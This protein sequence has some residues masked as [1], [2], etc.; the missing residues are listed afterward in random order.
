MD[1]LSELF[2]RIENSRF[3][4]LI[5]FVVTRDPG[6]SHGSQ[7]FTSIKRVSGNITYQSFRRKFFGI[8]LEDQR[9]WRLWTISFIYFLI[10]FALFALEHKTQGRH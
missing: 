2:L 8:R 7:Y 1:R 9:L 10:N 3:R 4:R 6:T 5:K